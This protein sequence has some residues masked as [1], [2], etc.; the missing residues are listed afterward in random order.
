MP[1]ADKVYSITEISRSVRRLLESHLGEVWVEGEVSNHR[2]QVSG[3]QYF[4]LKD[5]SAQ[6]NCVLFRGNARMG[7]TRVENGAQ[8][9]AFGELTVYEARGQYQLIVRMVQAKGVG[10]LQAKFEALKKK[11]DGEG[12]FDPSTKKPIPAFPQTVAI[13]TSPTGAALRDILNIMRR[14]APWVRV[15]ISPVRVQGKGA[16]KEIA[17]AI[18]DLN[19]ESGKSLPKIDTIV[20]AR[21]GGSIEDLW[22]F[23]EEVVARAVHASKSPSP[24][25]RGPRN[26][27][28]DR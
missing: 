3:H 25:G 1:P 13:V 6:L 11:L 27:L 12:L 23:N 9:Q 15:L 17:T 10:A 21:G 22:N 28:Y 2:A 19:R 18:A 4:T 8:I 14:R 20:V 7:S 24:L 26:R 5:E 16:E